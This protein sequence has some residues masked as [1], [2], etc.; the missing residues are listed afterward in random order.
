MGFIKFGWYNPN[1]PN[2]NPKNSQ[3]RKPNK[4]IYGNSIDI[5]GK[6]H[7]HKIISSIKY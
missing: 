2:D 3:I 7:M 1:N 4:N 5:T 6:T